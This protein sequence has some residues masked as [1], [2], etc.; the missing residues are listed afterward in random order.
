MITVFLMPGLGLGHDSSVS[1]GS[2]DSAAVKMG[3]A[4]ALAEMETR[5]SNE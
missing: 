5:W 2:A 3:T 1:I 4:A